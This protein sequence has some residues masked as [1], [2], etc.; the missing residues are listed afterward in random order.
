MAS[1]SLMAVVAS[2]TEAGTAYPG[3]QVTFT[4]GATN[5]KSLFTLTNDTL[6]IAGD[7]SETNKWYVGGNQL[8]GI[9]SIFLV[10]ADGT[11][12]GLTAQSGYIAP[13]STS[14]SHTAWTTFSSS[15]FS[16]FDDG[17]SG[18]GFPNGSDY[19][20]VGNA[21]T[22]GKTGVGTE[23]FGSFKFSGPLVDAHGQPLY[24]LGLDCLIGPGSGVTERVYFSLPAY[25]A[26]VP[27]AST[28]VT[29]GLLGGLSL[30]VLRRRKAVVKAKD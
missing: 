18:K 21:T 25:V 24:D 1:A 29:F 9:R 5:T 8:V 26:P 19:L 20:L 22:A 10:K 12:T 7:P 13:T 15:G 23:P 4:S 16:I 30:L 3:N 11:S 6:T 17:A 2:R 28:V 14:S 27:E